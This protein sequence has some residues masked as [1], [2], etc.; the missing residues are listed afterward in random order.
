MRQRCVG[1]AH[2]HQHDCVSH[3][4]PTVTALGLSN[5]QTGQRVS[6]G[7][8]PLSG[9][10]VVS[11]L[12]GKERYVPQSRRNAGWARNS[13]ECLRR[14][15]HPP[16]RGTVSTAEARNNIARTRGRQRSRVA[17]VT[18]EPAIQWG[19]LQ[20]HEERLGAS[21][22]VSQGMIPCGRL[23]SDAPGPA[24][25]LADGA[26]ARWRPGHSHS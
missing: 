19:G 3:A 12:L 1:V 24:V 17:A 13:N 4:L 14:Q 10:V 26:S 20:R 15:T 18:R 25:T 7:S 16:R 21:A 23:C 2:I 22:D 9:L 8:W 5:K 11:S 6:S